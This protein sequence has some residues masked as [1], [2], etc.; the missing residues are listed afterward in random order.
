MA[1]R[2]YET[3][4]N[5]QSRN[6]AVQ[7]TSNN[8]I[9]GAILGGIAG[10][11]VGMLF[12][13]KTGKELRS[14]LNQQANSLLDK[15]VKLS[16]DAVEKGGGLAAVTKEKAA[17]LSKAVVEQSTGMIRKALSSDEENPTEENAPTTYI[18]LQTKPADHEAVAEEVMDND[19]EVK[20]RLEEAKRAFDEEENRI[21]LK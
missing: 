7:G 6:D 21:S 13:P 11:A 8:F 17:S 9:L 10:A 14:T 1:N 15:S 19:E 16:G 18:P 12:A 4:E 20:K 3:R 5:H 2:E